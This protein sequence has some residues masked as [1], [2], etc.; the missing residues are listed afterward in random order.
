[1]T[2]TRRAAL[3]AAAGAL[4]GALSAPRAFAAP[5]DP[6]ALRPERVADG[7]WMIEGARETFSPA[8]GGAICNVAILETD[9]GALVV[10]TGVSRRHGE[11]LRGLANALSPRGV[12]MAVVTH[13][14]PDHAFGGQAFADAPVGALGDS[15]AAFDEQAGSYAEALYRMVGDAMRGTEPMPPTRALTG[16]ALTVGGREL[17]LLPLGGHTG[18]DLALLDRRTGTL[19]AG[20]LAFL[21]RG[22]A[23]PDADLGRW[24]ASL[25]DLDALGAGGILPGHGPFDRTGESL[26]QTRAYLDW[27]EATLTAAAEAGLSMAEAAALPLP[28]AFA[29]QG[30]QP[31]EFVRSVSHLYP[32]LERAALP[33]IE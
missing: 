32:A 27:L 31:Q 12:A 15:I 22:P 4:A 8:N 16:G 24:R 13:H 26:R 6:Y 30:A 2:L 18:A 11:A 1:V 23:T 19:L 17:A 9:A 33:K 20:D 28:T 3:G 21:D 5:R 29:A 25:S 10:E 7:L 14:H